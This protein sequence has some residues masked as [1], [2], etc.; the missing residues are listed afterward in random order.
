MLW[1]RYVC[2]IYRLFLSVLETFKEFQTEI[3]EGGVAELIFTAM[4]HMQL[5]CSISP[6][7]YDFPL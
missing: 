4:H 6:C 2:D 3:L 5:L 1:K 7:A